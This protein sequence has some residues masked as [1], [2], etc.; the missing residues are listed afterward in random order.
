MPSLRELTALLKKISETTDKVQI[1][2]IDYNGE[3]F[4]WKVPIV[5]MKASEYIPRNSKERKDYEG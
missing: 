3:E 5:N 4:F 1:Q 2:Q